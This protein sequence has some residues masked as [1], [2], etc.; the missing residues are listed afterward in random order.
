MDFKF[1]FKKKF[2]L[3]CSVTDLIVNLKKIIM[4]RQFNNN[5]LMYITIFVLLIL[6][7]SF[8]V[9]PSQSSPLPAIKCSI[10]APETYVYKNFFKEKL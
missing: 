5:Y 9:K 4:A 6:V 10:N 2:L 8:F 7:N 1:S 3:V